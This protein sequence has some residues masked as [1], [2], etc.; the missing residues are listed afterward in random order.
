M[1]IEPD[2][3]PTFI[4]F[5]KGAQVVSGL[6]FEMP[7]KSPDDPSSPL[8]L[9]GLG[10]IYSLKVSCVDLE[11]ENPEPEALEKGALWLGVQGA[12]DRA[13]DESAEAIKI[14]RRL[15]AQALCP[16]GGGEGGCTGGVSNGEV[17]AKRREELANALLIHAFLCCRAGSTETARKVL[18]E[19]AEIHPEA[20]PW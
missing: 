9:E 10:L 14:R 11:G 8:L 17:V 5:I 15:L 2:P 12:Y 20:W 3:D 1:K 13:L 18:K 19:V 16:R 4:T 7:E 6:F